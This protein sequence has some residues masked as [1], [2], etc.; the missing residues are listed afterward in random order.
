R[1]QRISLFSSRRRHTRCS[2]DWSSD[3]CSSDLNGAIYKLAIAPAVAAIRRISPDRIIIADGAGA[4]NLA[5]P[6]LIP[7]GV[8]QSVHCYIQIGGAS[9]RQRGQT[10]CEVTRARALATSGKGE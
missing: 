2:R 10:I 9:R 3:V 4:G 8:H 5:V 6:E 7:L 1:A